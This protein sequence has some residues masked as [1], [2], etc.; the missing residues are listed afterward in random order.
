MPH[1]THS[2]TETIFR[3]KCGCCLSLLDENIGFQEESLFCNDMRY[4]SEILVA[5]NNA[6]A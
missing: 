1:N 2:D 6:K 3:Y 4:E 5:K